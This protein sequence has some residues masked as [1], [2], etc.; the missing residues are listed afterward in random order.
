MISFSIFKELSVADYVT[1]TGGI[2][3]ILSITGCIDLIS[4]GF[5][6]DTFKRTCILFP[7]SYFLD[8]LDGN[9]ARSDFIKQLAKKID[10]PIAVQSD[11]GIYID[12]LA[13]IIIYT[14]GPVVFGYAVFKL[15][16]FLDVLCQLFFVCCALSR[17]S[18]SISR[19]VKAIVVSNKRKIYYFKGVPT[20]TSIFFII[21]LFYFDF[22]FFNGAIIKYKLYL[23]TVPVH[24]GSLLYL[25]NGILNLSDFKI[26][27]DGLCNFEMIMFWTFIFFV[28][29]G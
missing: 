5:D 15:N 21:I 1:L 4:N 26:S 7:V 2:C 24:C 27:K 3:A 8:C 10:L 16:L 25:L 11:F 22:Y 20:T 9:V 12:K 23:L 28:W 29:F 6:I 17:L 14:V 18:R 19:S 13:D